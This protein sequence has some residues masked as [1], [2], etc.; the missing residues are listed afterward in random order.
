MGG[1]P[2]RQTWASDRRPGCPW[3]GGRG[4]RRSGRGRRGCNSC[5]FAFVLQKRREGG[6]TRGNVGRGEGKEKE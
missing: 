1:E 4:P 6:G 5:E 3:A 2:R